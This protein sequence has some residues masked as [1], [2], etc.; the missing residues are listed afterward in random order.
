MS[1]L[2]ADPLL[3][4]TE[5]FRL[6][7]ERRG[8]RIECKGHHAPKRSRLLGEQDRE[9]LSGLRADATFDA[10]CVWDYGVGVYAQAA[11]V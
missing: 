7:A 6:W 9:Y 4:E 8:Y 1:D 3:R 5:N 10:A 2:I 11:G